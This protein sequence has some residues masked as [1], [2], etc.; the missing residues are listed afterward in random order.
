[1]ISETMELSD[2]R[3]PQE[4]QIRLPSSTSSIAGFV[5]EGLGQVVEEALALAVGRDI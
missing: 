2:T 4:T 1:M 3:A 5:Q